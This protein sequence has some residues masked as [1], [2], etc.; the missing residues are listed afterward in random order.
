M[1]SGVVL[2][3]GSS[4]RMQQTK[5]L[6]PVGEKPMLQHVVDVA[7]QAALDEILVI[8]GH[9]ADRVRD[10]VKLPSNARFVLNLDYE[11]GMSTSLIAGLE[12][13]DPTAE[14]VVVLMGD[15][16]LLSP[17][18][19]RTLI[20]TYEETRMPVVC[21]M[22]RDAPGPTLLAVGI[23]ED[24]MSVEGDTGAR[25]FID[26]NPDLVEEVAFD[27]NAPTDVDT[28]EDCRRVLEESARP[29]EDEA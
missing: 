13:A 14:A 9:D 21:A 2:A 4:S 22:F 5:P 1:I 25:A 7:F 3:A 29:R 27:R 15:Q 17:A 18:V 10:G 8:V 6:M 16:P 24:L 28:E 20:T 23:W 19:V 11:A 26:E 12:A